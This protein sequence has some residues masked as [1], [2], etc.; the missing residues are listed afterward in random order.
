MSYEKVYISLLMCVPEVWYRE[1]GERG[2]SI[3]GNVVVYTVS[4][5]I[6]G[7][8]RGECFIIYFFLYFFYLFIFLACGVMEVEGR[9]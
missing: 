3:G 7:I 8:P 5:N 9:E 2:E 4:R 6:F 1:R